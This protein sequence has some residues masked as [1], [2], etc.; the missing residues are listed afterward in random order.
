VK[1]EV[2]L[3]SPQKAKSCEPKASGA[4]FTSV[5]QTRCNRPFRAKATGHRASLSRF[6]ASLKP[7]VAYLVL[8]FCALWK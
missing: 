7:N 5:V 1:E 6:A 3:F 8:N 4:S 2:D